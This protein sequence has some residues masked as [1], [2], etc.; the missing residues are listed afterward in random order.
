FVTKVLMN[1]AV[2]PLYLSNDIT[3]IGVETFMSIMGTVGHF[4]LQSV[5]LVRQVTFKVIHGGYLLGD[6]SQ[7]IAFSGKCEC[8]P[9]P[10]WM[11]REDAAEKPQVG[12]SLEGYEL[13]H[14]GQGKAHHPGQA[15]WCTH[16]PGGSAPIQV[17]Q[18][19]PAARKV[20][21]QATIVNGIEDTLIA[22]LEDL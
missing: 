1:R 4:F 10:V 12:R 7:V 13:L 11:M 14:T 8:V 21:F 15:Q 17:L 20:L 18:Q 3:D 19:G 6:F 9:E 22:G 2:L 5:N 16:G